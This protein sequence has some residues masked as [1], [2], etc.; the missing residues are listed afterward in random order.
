MNPHVGQRHTA[1]IR[2]IAAPQRSHSILSASPAGVTLRDESGRTGGRGGVSA[3]PP[4]MSQ[5]DFEDLRSS[6]VAD[7]LVR[8]GIR[9]PRVLD[10][11]SRVPRHLFVPAEA[12]SLAYADRALAIGGQTI[13]QPYMVAVMTQALALLGVSVSSRL[14]PDRLSGGDP[15]RACPRGG[16]HRAPRRS[17]RGR[18]RAP[19]SRSVQEH[20]CRGRRRHCAAAAAYPMTRSW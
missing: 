5:V 7:Q 10:A 8:R 4:I 17:G 3:M 11:M 6:M 20:Q 14:E 1:C 13:P 19:P 9:D 2:Y 12:V 16:D 15:R 18:A